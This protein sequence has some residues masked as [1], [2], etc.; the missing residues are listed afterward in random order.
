[1][2]Y[3]ALALVVALA[4]C[5][6]ADDTMVVDEAEVVADDA[7]AAATTYDGGPALGTYEAISTDGTVLTQTTWEDGT[8][9]TVDADGNEVLGV[10]TMENER[11][12]ITNEG[13]TEASCYA[14]S[15]RTDDGSWTATNEAD[16]EDVWMI[17]RIES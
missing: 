13:E 5:T 4:A 17:R 8:V 9:S 15:D 7:E 10:Y 3:L 11:F 12:C 1:M 16:P 2:K 14:Y 6:E